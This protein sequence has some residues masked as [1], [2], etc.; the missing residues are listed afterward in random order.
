MALIKGEAG[1]VAADFQ[2][3]RFLW[4]MVWLGVALD[5]NNLPAAT[6]TNFLRGDGHARQASTVKATVFLLPDALRG[7]NP[8]EPAGVGL[9][10]Q[11]RF[12]CL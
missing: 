12:G 3:G 6:Q 4:L 11:R 1:R 9:E 2:R 5:G 8:A 10:P 7:E